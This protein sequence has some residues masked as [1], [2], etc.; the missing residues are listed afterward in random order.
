MTKMNGFK[1]IIVANSILAALGTGTVFHFLVSKEL[2]GA[3]QF[4]KD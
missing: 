2:K 3:F 4:S 1:S